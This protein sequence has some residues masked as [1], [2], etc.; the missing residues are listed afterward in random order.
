MWIFVTIK[1]DHL[2]RVC[3]SILVAGGQLYWT[4]AFP[5]CY[6]RWSRE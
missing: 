4:A 3:N 6:E 1:R 2:D 5:V